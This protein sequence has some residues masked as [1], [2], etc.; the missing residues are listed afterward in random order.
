[1]EFDQ[2]KEPDHWGKYIRLYKNYL[3]LE[4]GLSENSMISY[5]LDVLKFYRYLHTHDLMVDLEILSEEEV[6]HFLY[7][8][9]SVIAPAT[10]SRIISGLKGFF[11]FLV[12]ERYIQQ[13]PMDL[14][15]IPKLGRSLPEVLSLEEIDLLV[16]QIDQAT[17]EGYR[18]R[19]I[20]ETLYGCGLRVT[21]L[22]TLRLSDLFFDEGFI[23]IIGKGSK[24][25]LVPIA[26]DTIGYL[27]RY[28]DEIRTHQSIK[29]EA[30]DIVF[31]NR[32][33]GQLSRAMIFTI[34]KRLAVKAS[35]DKNISPHT[36]RH[37]F[38]THLLEHGADIRAIQLMLGHESITTTEIYTHVNREHLRK[39]L[40]DCHPRNS[41]EF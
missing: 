18:N 22:V 11:N 37:S 2:Q 17:D 10:Q 8:I 6:Q 16:E 31:L 24:H 23:R 28:I 41:K 25:R 38:A 14:I 12:L 1:M 26:P 40:V 15:E 39:V 20:I 3:K 34:I 4:R 36:F 5:E 13:S 7:A 27:S 29:K 30:S 21:E 19:V 9:S 35:I 32:R 33:G